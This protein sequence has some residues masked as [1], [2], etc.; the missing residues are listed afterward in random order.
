M[1][2]VTWSIPRSLKSAAMAWSDSKSYK[3]KS[4]VYRSESST[5]LASNACNCTIG[6]IETNEEPNECHRGAWKGRAKVS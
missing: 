4:H 1:R 3:R 2:N 5:G 6:H